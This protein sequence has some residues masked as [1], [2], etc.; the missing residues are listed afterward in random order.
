MGN[1]IGGGIARPRRLGSANAVAAA[2]LGEQDMEKEAGSYEKSCSADPELRTFHTALRRRASRAI[3]AVASGVEVRSLSLGSLRDVT[4]CLLDMNQEVVRVVLASKRDVWRSPDLFDLVEGY[5]EGSLH[6]LD[7]LA[8]LDASLRRA[9][10]AQLPLH[11]ALKGQEP[12]A[13]DRYARAL[14][15]L[16]RVKAPGEP[17]TAE[18]FAAFQTVYREQVAMMG[19]LRQR[20]RQLDGRVRSVR[21]W[22]RVS[23]VVFVTT[24]AVLLV[25]SVVAAAIAALLIC[26]VVAAAARRRGTGRCGLPTRGLSGEVGGFAA[27]AV[28]GGAPWVQ[29]GREH[30]A[31]RGL[32]CN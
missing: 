22:H 25:C 24:F 12:G 29:G 21:A 18:F 5:F 32:H 6:T 14:V 2:V 3:T 17:F 1:I 15:E 8:A 26:S 7:F 31:G 10:D 9:R 16:R 30:N 23:S 27:E 19:K 20:K 13:A 4:G 28:P 11:L